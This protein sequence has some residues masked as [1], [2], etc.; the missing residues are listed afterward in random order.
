MIALVLISSKLST[1]IISG[2]S[3][4]TVSES[5][6]LFGFCSTKFDFSFYSINKKKMN[7]Y[8]SHNIHVSYFILFLYKP[9]HLV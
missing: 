8:Y 7:K 3:N 2:F 4:C 5:V 1:S 9:L 6:L